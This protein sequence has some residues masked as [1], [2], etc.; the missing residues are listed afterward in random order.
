MDEIYNF[1]ETLKCF[2]LSKD[3]AEEFNNVLSANNDLKCIYCEIKCRNSEVEK[4]NREHLKYN[5][6]PNCGAENTLKNIT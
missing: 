4:S 5:K 2:S 3:L 1:V 6:C